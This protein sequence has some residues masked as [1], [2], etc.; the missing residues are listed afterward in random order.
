[1]I[2]KKSPEEIDKMARAGAILIAVL[3][4]LQGKVR[5][6][7]STAELDQAASG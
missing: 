4:M 2:I 1:M 7:V 3:D 5:P 6:G